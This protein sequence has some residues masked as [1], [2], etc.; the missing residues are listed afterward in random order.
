MADE[1]IV[2][3]VVDTKVVPSETPATVMDATDD[4]SSDT[5]ASETGAKSA[6]GGAKGDPDW[7]ADW[8]EKAAGGDQKKLS[9]LGRYASP[10]ALADAL[11]AAQNKISAGELKPAL[12]KDAKPEEIAA[13]REALG[14]PESPDKY[15]LNGIELT[16]DDKPLIEKFVGAAHGVNMTPAQVR[17][18]LEAYSQISD[19]VR[20]QRA[21][22]DN[23]AKEAAEDKLRA[24]WGNEFRT[25]LN[26]ITN[27]LDTAPQGV[28]EKLLTGRLSDGTPIGSSVEVLQFLANLARDR[29][30]TGVVAP[31]GVATES[32]VE[33]EIAKIEKVLRED[34]ATYNRDQK[35]QDRY[36]QLL[37]WRQSQGR[38]AA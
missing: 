1:N 19:E 3:E 18:S 29:N 37:E 11:I 13:Y 32:A 8:R 24:E 17:A 2:D 34:R 27:L 36:R 35:M 30:P 23:E 6:S 16:E 7:P 20:G 15:D 10:Q 9:R 12:G 33:D 5:Q 22:I 28:R 4:N 21:A 14:I 26:L 25:N 38:R 31:S